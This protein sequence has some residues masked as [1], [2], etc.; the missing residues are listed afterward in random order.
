MFWALNA[1]KIC[2]I[3]DRI[4]WMQNNEDYPHVWLELLL[5]EAL[6]AWFGIHRVLNLLTHWRPS[7]S[8]ACAYTV[9]PGQ[10]E[11]SMAACN[12]CVLIR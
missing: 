3:G 4:F 10:F 11:S 6:P 2:S 7:L 8:P 12:V 5:S 9:G 1:V